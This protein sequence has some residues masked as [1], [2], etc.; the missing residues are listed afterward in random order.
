[1]ALTR[2]EPSGASDLRREMD[3]LLDRFWGLNGH[4]SELSA[5]A[6]H[7]TVD[8]TEKDDAYVVTA[9]LPGM[10]RDE[11]KVETN[12]NTVTIS[13][14]RKSDHKDEQS[15]R[16]ERSYGRFHRAFSMPSKFDA[17]NVSAA[18]TDGVLTVTLPKAEEAKP[19]S[20]KIS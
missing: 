9:D 14:E 1:M 19:K 7:P 11:I 15:H 12:E 5:A 16:T 2:W 18:Y 4:R 10:S 17:S 13:G 20:V 3:H 6:W 8:V